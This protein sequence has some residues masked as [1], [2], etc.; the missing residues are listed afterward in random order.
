M[1]GPP[2]II[3]HPIS[4]LLNA[5]MNIPLHCEATGRG[6][7]T[8][9]W[10]SSNINGGHWTMIN[11]TNNTTYVV[12][13]LEQSQQCRCVASNEAGMATSQ[14]ANITILSKYVK[15]INSYV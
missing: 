4:Y 10:E 11:N 3:T 5:S 12:S 15:Q 13:N 14:I 8:Y 2:T 9:Q 7:I 1:T 6:S